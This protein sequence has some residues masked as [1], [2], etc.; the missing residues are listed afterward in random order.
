MGMEQL[1]LFCVNPTEELVFSVL[2]P[3][4]DAVVVKNN[5]PCKKLLLEQLKNYSS[6]W[7][8]SLMA[9]R[10]CCRGK[11]HYF[12]IPSL[13]INLV[14]DFLPSDISVSDDGKPFFRMDF[15]STSNGILRFAPFLSAVLDRVIDSFPKEFDCCSRFEECSDAKKCIHPNPDVAIACGY[16]KILKGGTIL[17]GKN[18]NV[19]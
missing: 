17:T 1:D 16:R 13:Y 14:S 9:F 4:L 18:R 6:V 7:F 8:D 2:Q 15:E 5:G 19:D 12:E 11:K 3:Y 10:I